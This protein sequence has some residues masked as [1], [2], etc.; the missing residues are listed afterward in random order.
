[1]LT[2]YDEKKQKREERIRRFQ[3]EPLPDGLPDDVKALIDDLSLL[4]G[5]EVQEDKIVNQLTTDK[6][7]QIIKD[8]GEECMLKN[9]LIWIQTEV[10]P[11]TVGY[12]DLPMIYISSEDI[13]LESEEQLESMNKAAEEV[14]LFWS[15][16]KIIVDQD[17]LFTVNFLEARHE[18]EASFRQ[19]FPFYLYQIVH[20]TKELHE[21]YNEYEMLRTHL[22]TRK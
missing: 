18:D 17:G 6:I 10:G 9:N 16:V 13:C 2:E 3:S 11:V 19:N 22:S 20:A 7:L 14:T 8:C 1:M 12:E 15:M 21:R 5:S 4:P